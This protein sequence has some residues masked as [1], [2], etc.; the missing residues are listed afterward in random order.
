MNS[1]RLPQ[2]RP[3]L[4]TT[5]FAS[6]CS[7]SRRQQIESSQLFRCRELA[8]HT[9]AIITTELSVNGTLMISGGRDTT[10]LLWSI[11]Q[12]RSAWNSIA[13]ETNHQ[14]TVRCLAFSPDNMR[15]FSGGDDGKILIH[16]TQS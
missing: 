4:T 12:G 3:S 11:N 13:M 14:S 7:S 15:I 10:V 5:S 8:G 9:D 6:N 2:R 1:A 16:D